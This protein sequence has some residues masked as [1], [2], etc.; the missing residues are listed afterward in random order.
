MV[1]LDHLDHPGYP[2]VPQHPPKWPVLD[3]STPVGA[4]TPCRARG[5]RPARAAEGAAGPGGGGRRPRR[6]TTKG[7]GTAAGSVA[8]AEKLSAHE[9]HSMQLVSE[10]LARKSDTIC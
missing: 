7:T 3:P 8:A 2:S 9:A 4:A 10:A 6:A 5:H 1:P